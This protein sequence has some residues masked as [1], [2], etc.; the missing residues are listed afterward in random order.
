M[1][2]ALE[3][4]SVIESFERQRAHSRSVRLRDFL[5]ANDSAEFS[6]VLTEL[7][8]VDLEYSWDEGKPKSLDEYLTEFP[9]LKQDETALTAIAF[10]EYRQRQ[11]AGE[12]PSAA[13][14]HRRY[15]ISTRDWPIPV[16]DTEQYDQPT[17]QHSF[18][19]I[20][21]SSKHQGSGHVQEDTEVA[22]LPHAGS[23][24]LDFVLEEELGKGAFGKVYLARQKSLSNRLVAIKI[25]SRKQHEPQTLAKLR[26]TNIM[27]IHSVHEARHWQAI[28]MP[29]LGK[30]TLAD[31]LGS[32]KKLPVLPASG[33]W[34]TTFIDKDSPAAVYWSKTTYRDAV[35]HLM[36][37]MAAGLAHAHMNGIVHRDIKPANILLS[38]DGEP[39][40]LDFNLA[41]EV[42]RSGSLAAMAGTLPYLAPEQLTATVRGERTNG[43]KQADVYAL[44]LIL[45]ELLSGQRAYPLIEEKTLLGYISE[46]ARQRQHSPVSLQQ[47]Q[48]SISPAVASIVAKCLAVDPAQ[49]YADAQE[50]HADLQR[51]LQHQVLLHAPDHSIMERMGKWRRRHPQFI[52]RGVLFLCLLLAAL[53]GTTGYYRLQSDRKLTYQTNFAD[54]VSK[55]QRAERLATSI[56]PSQLKS[57]S[58]GLQQLLH[59]DMGEAYL[60][61][62]QRLQLPKL[63]A[64][65][66]LL[67]ARLLK[68]QAV[69]TSDVSEQQK[70]NEQALLAN[71]QAQLWCDRAGMKALGQWQR[72][73][74][75]HGP[76]SELLQSLQVASQDAL[77]PRELALLASS[78]LDQAQ[79]QQAATIIKK[80]IDRE[81]GWSG[82][83]FLNGLLHVR[84]GQLQEAL[85]G[86]ETALALEPDDPITLHYRG[87]VLL[88]LG[89][90]EAA[91]A[92][93]NKALKLDASQVDL[94]PD[95]A[96][97][98]R[99]TNELPAAI[100]TLNRVLQIAPEQQ[101]LWFLR[102]DIKRQLGDL[103]G[104]AE[105]R[106]HGFTLE[107]RNEIEQV[108]RGIALREEGKL[109]EALAAYQTAEQI[110]PYYLPAMEN[111]SELLGE[112]LQKPAE[113]LAVLN[114]AVERIPESSQLYAARAVYH[115]RLGNRDAAVQDAKSALK[116]EAL[117][118]PLTLYQIGCVYALTSRK[119]PADAFSALAYLTLAL[120]R[121]FGQEYLS[122]DP[123]LNPLRSRLD[124][125][126][127]Q[128]RYVK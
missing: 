94:L 113:A 112:Q 17:W 99:Q 1:S 117:P 103:K 58:D 36:E 40:L 120:E 57:A 62:E 108:V 61:S 102:A 72:H 26:H 53:A 21:S 47:L 48:P 44:G 98:Q 100:T 101:R 126:D 116:Y 127:L 90:F 25:T 79:W 70:L 110:A 22:K 30:T 83:W 32:L 76:S 67:H 60:T 45:Y 24:F 33:E 95:I 8:R 2:A 37:K 97:V 65:G 55:L 7:I 27:P 13:E 64:Q 15:H 69:K 46:L 84:G 50:L 52:G 96:L 114:R 10:E 85:H 77:N 4:D 56:W 9:T 51:Q 111:Q 42:D 86:F 3:L 23:S 38:R 104:A 29:Y 16:S 74:L 19:E 68:L 31:L 43:S 59:H 107:S 125:K 128:K 11:R 82:A 78:L 81:P 66:W 71:T 118:K 41:I 39:L 54:T 5:P 28:C 12:T 63:L 87:K 14:Y 49:R 115:A 91:L 119:Q 6:A 121:Q 89:L 123:D 18:A 73:V 109:N 122:S 75:N 80:I 88:Q 92:D 20:A 124:F 35:L 106:R 105:D 93:F 34:W